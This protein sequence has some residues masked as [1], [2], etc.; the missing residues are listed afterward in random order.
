MVSI[1]LQERKTSFLKQ[2]QSVQTKCTL[3]MKP[4]YSVSLVAK[5]FKD[6]ITEHCTL[7]KPRGKNHYM[8]L[9]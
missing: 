8:Q 3:I 9:M 1:N 6:T 2:N 7:Q 5:R 4:K